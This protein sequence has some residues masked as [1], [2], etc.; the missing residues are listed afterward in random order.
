MQSPMPHRTSTSIT[1][2]ARSLIIGMLWHMTRQLPH[3][4]EDEI[5]S[6]IIT[7]DHQSG[8]PAGMTFCQP[9]TAF[10]PHFGQKRHFRSRRL[11]VEVLVPTIAEV[12]EAVGKIDD[13]S[14]FLKAVGLNNNVIAQLG[15][16]DGSLPSLSAFFGH[17]PLRGQDRQQYF[18]EDLDRLFA[19]EGLSAESQRQHIELLRVVFAHNNLRYCSLVGHVH[20][21]VDQAHQELRAV[22]QDMPTAFARVLFGVVAQT[23][24]LA[25]KFFLG[26][27]CREVEEQTQ[28]FEYF[29]RLWG[30]FFQIY[31]WEDEPPITSPTREFL[32]KGLWPFLGEMEE[33]LNGDQNVEEEPQRDLDLDDEEEVPEDDPRIDQDRF[34]FYRQLG[35]KRVVRPKGWFEGRGYVAYLIKTKSGR[36][37]AVLDCNQ[38]GNA[39]YLFWMRQDADEHMW[40]TQAQDTKR[41]VL[42]KA[43]TH[44]HTFIRRFIHCTG[45]ELRVTNWVNDN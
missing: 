42:T 45:W 18:R 3:A 36:P 2:S 17:R 22:V 26:K 32:P 29:T 20:R 19:F 43:G 34:E 15:I 16:A 30:R 40:L 14:D 13:A 39:A 8:L 44:G 28:E 9:A 37:V 11:D 1:L 10:W 41:E 35:C 25:Y 6:D 4:P 38:Y 21:G 27:S 12:L 31:Y 5:P 23:S 24:K 33:V 7:F